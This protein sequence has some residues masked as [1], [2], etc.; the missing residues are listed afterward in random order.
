MHKVSEGGGI[1]EQEN[2]EK[3]FGRYPRNVNGTWDGRRRQ[4]FWESSD[5][6]GR[7]R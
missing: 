1:N 6:K 7:N 5:S 2:N 4:S 3:S